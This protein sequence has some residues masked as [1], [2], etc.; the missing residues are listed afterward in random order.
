[1]TFLQCILLGACYWLGNNNMCCS[2]TCWW[3]PI[4][5]GF[6]AGLVLGDP[7]QGAIIGANI[8]LIYIGV[9]GAGG[10]TP[11]DAA[12]AGIVATA[13]TITYGY[14][15][16]MALA[17]A[18]PLG[19][20]G[21]VI[22]PIFMTAC[23]YFVHLTEKAIN[24]KKFNKIFWTSTLLPIIFRIVCYII[25]II[26]M[27]YFGADYVAALVSKLPEFV[28]RAFS[29][30]GGMLPAA[31]IAVNLSAIYK[32]KAK[33]FLFVGFVIAAYTTLPV[34]ATAIIGVV[35]AIIYVQLESKAEESAA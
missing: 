6:M 27:L 5:A 10:A 8:N 9:I 19:V 21:N 17:M 15:V 24:D 32:G 30:V 4:V 18:V 12:L 22:S 33:V 29:A 1:M 7:A 26:L 11:G 25:P 14:S 2:F 13:L 3:R 34:M 31:G 35:L 28:T 20:L 23:T 16:D